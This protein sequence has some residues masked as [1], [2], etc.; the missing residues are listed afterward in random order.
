VFRGLTIEQAVER[1]DSA[2]IANARMNSMRE[3]WEH[4][5]HTARNRWREVDSPVGLLPALLPPITLDGLEARMEPVPAL[6]EHTELILRELRYSPQQ[7]QLL[8]DEEAI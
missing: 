6:G 5:Q 7:I 8:R 2:G 4:P 3:F 1:L